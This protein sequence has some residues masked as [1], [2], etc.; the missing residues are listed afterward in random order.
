VNEQSIFIAAL[1]RDPHERGV[2][3]DEAC[4]GNVPLRQRVDKLLASHEAAIGFMDQPAGRLAPTTNQQPLVRSGMQIGPYKLREQIGE[5]GFGVVY[6]AEQETPVRRKVALKIIK[7]GMDTKDV[8]AR[9]EA[10]RQALALMDHPNVARVL[11]AGATETGRPYFVMELVHGVPVT[12]YCDKNKLPTRDRLLLFADIC[13]AVQHAHQKG[14]IHRDLKP[15]NI[16]VT[17]HD[18]KPV[19]KVIDFG[20]SKALSQQLTE[21]SIYTSYGQMIGT[22]SYMSPE[23]AEMSGLGIDTRSD[24]YSLG[25][26]LYELLTGGTPLD[27]KRLRSSAYAEILRI[28]REE[29]PQRPSLKISTLGDQATIIAEHRHTDPTHLRRELTGE[30]DWIVM[31][32]LDKDRG[33]RY[34]TANGLARD[35]ERYLHDEPVEACPPALSY[36]LKKF[37]RRNKGPVLAAS[38]VLLALCG[39]VVATA[40]QAVRATRAETR[41]IA[42]SLEKERARQEAVASANQALAAA[43][44]E[45]KARDLAQRRLSQIEKANDI[46]ASIFLDLDPRAEELGKP[47]RAQ[48]GERLERA[49][50]HLDA[51]AVGDPLTVARLQHTLGISQ[52]ILGHFAQ[53]IGP[54]EKAVKT[55]TELLG[56]SHQETLRARGD[57]AAAVAFSG[58][59]ARAIEINEQVW[60]AQKATLGPDHPDTLE[61][62]FRLAAG[63]WNAGQREKALRVLE[64]AHARAQEALGPNDKTS[65][66]MTNWLAM[67]R[68][69]SGQL[70]Q[71][72]P[73]LEKT[74]AWQKETLGL[75]HVGTAFTMRNVAVAYRS[76]GQFDKALE[77]MK[78]AATKL[79]DQLGEDHPE[80]AVTLNSISR[81]YRMAGQIDD[82]ALPR[83]DALFV[84]QKST[85]G[86]DHL[87]TMASRDSLAL[88]HR[89]NGNYARA[90]ELFLEA[91]ALK[92][93]KL[94]SDDPSITHTMASLGWNSVR[95]KRFAEA[96]TILRECLAIRAAK[97]SDKWQYFET[98]RALGAALLGQKRYAEAEPHLVQGFQGL[99]QREASMSTSNKPF[100]K[101]G[102]EQLIQLYDEWGKPDEA[103]KWKRELD[104]IK[105]PPDF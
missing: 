26:L 81:T 71:A 98:H 93:Q 31:K 83:L 27:A 11:D 51:E 72:L 15:S 87:K 5:G 17:L 95:Q 13:R 79:K 4:S 100:I 104:G 80:V 3:L 70:E 41:A 64:P 29:E 61:T 46:L 39:G 34:E 78:E 6:V 74:L 49:A 59:T 42:E 63:F 84:R 73:L 38:F 40:W 45:R 58:Q 88:T 57:L 92:K 105:T 21:K 86:P 7:P 69:E 97:E 52:R 96:E 24:I 30:L 66:L 103:A 91:L 90:E 8:I 67:M 53:S 16:M 62:E 85:L 2:F 9:F 44:Q 12:E 43:E 76:R 54:L 48:L 77:L 35:I 68:S 60:N 14:I 50:T 18:G 102:L 10:E 82:W 55:R 65:L 47:L 33:R 20:V 22:P 36:R 25:V 19:V 89:D 37:A 75:D 101:E 94:E 28:I 99:K 32:C 56:P 23:Q 1:E